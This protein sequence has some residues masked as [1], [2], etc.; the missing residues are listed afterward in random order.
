MAIQWDI[1]KEKI[2]AHTRSVLENDQLKNMR[3]GVK[4][5]SYWKLFEYLLTNFSIGLKLFGLYDKGHRRALDIKI[6][7]ITLEFDN[8]PQSFNG[9]KI[10]QLSDLHL[11]SDMQ[12]SQIITERIQTL[13]YDLCVMTGDYRL[14]A[15]GGFKN[16]IRPLRNIINSIRAKDGIY[17]ILGNHDTYLMVEEFEKMGINFLNNQSIDIINTSDK[18]SIT[19]TDDVHSYFTDQAVVE[20]EK[21]NDAF[22]IALVHS[23]ELYDVAADNNYSLYLCG[24]THGGQICLP[25]GKA[26]IAHLYNGKEYIKGLWKYKQM[27]G[28][29]ST[30]CGTS[31]IPVRI[32]SD[33]E[34]TLFELKQK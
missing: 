19:G 18:I 34:I 30:G 3:N 24:H 23:P 8:L 17:A 32:N 5:R 16:I 7:K 2:W 31:G 28:Y 9:Y 11:D 20:M 25:N 15:Y 26:L 6:N 13:N 12:L 27:Y 33:S 1:E 22:K 4:S 14:A 21:K 10:L 29:T